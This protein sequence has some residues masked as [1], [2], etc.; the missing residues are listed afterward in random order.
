MLLYLVYEVPEQKDIKIIPYFSSLVK[1]SE[2]LGSL[3]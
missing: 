1:D 2:L 3:C